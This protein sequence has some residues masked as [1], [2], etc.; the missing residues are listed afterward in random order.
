MTETA[1][2]DGLPVGPSRIAV[3][4]AGYVGVPT[5]AVLA[6]AGHD[7]VVAER[8]ADRRTALA[9]GRSP[10]ME[11]GLEELLARTLAS[12]RLRFVATAAEAVAGA[13][14]VV[15]CVATP[16]GPD[17]R[18]D[19]SDVDVAVGEIAAHLASGAV[20]VTKSTVPVGTT[21]RVARLLA[22]PDVHVASNPEFLREGHAVADARHPDRVV[23]GA[24]DPAVAD[25]VAS[26]SRDS[27]APQVITDP[28]T[29]E[30]VKYAAN[31]YLA[32]KLSFINSMAQLCDA[33]G[34][35]VGVLARGIGL[36]PR[37][38]PSFLTPG[39]GWGGSCL[40]KDVR[41]LQSIAADAHVTVPLVD[42]SRAV[43]DSQAD[44]VAERCAS[45]VT[46]GLDGAVV[47]VLGLTFKARTADRRDSPAL[48]VVR[49][50][51]AR[52][53]RVRAFDPTVA[54]GCADA[55]LAGIDLAGSADAAIEGARVV[56]VLTE[57]P[58][59]ARVAWGSHRPAA[60]LDT[61][62]VVD[63]GAAAAARWRVAVLGR[64]GS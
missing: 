39:P 9:A 26:L 3:I 43:N 5:A 32:M 11:E 47:G 15:L 61:R 6:D 64:P 37:I 53:A 28:R 59:F 36:D 44:Y 31:A 35:D 17:G 45:L 18:A 60:V 49:A 25:V 48:A 14:I 8:D 58:E 42:A 63:V 56:V 2:R 19:L 20:V 50:L 7:V 10:M 33:L 4:G 41:A 21:E 40:P 30:L 38:G 54:P 12:G 46:S 62:G 13:R 1:A 51:L 52:G 27:D 24:D 23:I 57:W 29:A 34:A 22:R 55:D 16:T